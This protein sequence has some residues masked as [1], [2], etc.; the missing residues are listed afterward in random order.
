MTGK[1]LTP[2]QAQELHTEIHRI[3]MYLQKLTSRM[4]ELQFQKNDALFLLVQHA[5]TSLVLLSSETHAL[6]R[7]LHPRSSKRSAFR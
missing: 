2:K 6:R 7:Q 5:E 1:D 3:S 4:V